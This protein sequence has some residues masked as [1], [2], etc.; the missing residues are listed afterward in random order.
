MFTNTSVATVLGEALL[1]T[2]TS[3]LVEFAFE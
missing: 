2:E 3:R 1:L